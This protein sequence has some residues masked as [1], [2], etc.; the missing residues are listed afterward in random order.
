MIMIHKSNRS[1]LFFLQRFPLVFSLSFYR[2]FCIIKEIIDC[3]I[4]LAMY[5][6]LYAYTF[7]TLHVSNAYF[8]NVWNMLQP[9][10]HVAIFWNIH[11]LG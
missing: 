6:R 7:Y 1:V 10:N 3:N 8:P 11:T 4:N 9:R 5:F 2:Y